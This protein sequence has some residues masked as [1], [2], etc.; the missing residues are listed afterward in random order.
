MRLDS[1]GAL[2]FAL[3]QMFQ[4]SSTFMTF[5]Q[6]IKDNTQIDAGDNEYMKLI[7]GKMT[8]FV[9]IKRLIDD[10]NSP[11]AELD[12]YRILLDQMKTDLQQ[13]I[14]GIP[15]KNDKDDSF[16]PLKSQLTPLGQVAF[17]INKQDKDSYLN[18]AMQWLDS[19]GI[20]KKW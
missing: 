19:V 1:S 7:S 18:L 17:A 2:R 6:T 16:A 11:T 12:K 3:N 4:P 15:K 8:D 13:E 14:C 20:T 5:L 10:K 9:F